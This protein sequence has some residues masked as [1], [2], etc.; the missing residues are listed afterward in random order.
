MAITGADFRG[1]NG[2]GLMGHEID[3]APAARQES[4][5]AGYAHYAR[6]GRCGPVY[7][8]LSSTGDWVCRGHADDCRIRGATTVAT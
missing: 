7:V 6:S 1:A 8:R 5:L 3:T 2:D 4:V